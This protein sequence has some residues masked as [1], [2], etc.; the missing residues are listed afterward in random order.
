MYNV[1]IDNKEKVVFTDLFIVVFVS[2]I[3]SSFC[4]EKLI[5]QRIYLTHSEII[6]SRYYNDYH[7]NYS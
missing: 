3:Y 5:T 6:A 2:I 1:C 4:I 7:P